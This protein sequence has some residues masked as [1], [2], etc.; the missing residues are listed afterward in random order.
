M[1]TT[2]C[3]FQFTKVQWR[4]LYHLCGKNRPFSDRMGFVML[5]FGNQIIQV[6]LS[7]SFNQKV[8]S[9]LFEIWLWKWVIVVTNHDL[10]EMKKIYILYF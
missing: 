1:N 3:R 2:S 10:Q 8:Q 5:N 7:Q 9:K 4:V 6:T